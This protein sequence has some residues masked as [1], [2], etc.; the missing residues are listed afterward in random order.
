MIEDKASGQSII[1]DLKNQGYV[2]IKPIKPRLDKITRFASIVE[3]FQ[4]GDVLLPK[5]SSFNRILLNELTSFPNSKHDDIIDSISQFLS[6]SK[7]TMQQKIVR[8][9]IL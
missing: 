4:R 6:F 1:Q 7:E 2:N 8:M 3:M 5:E 9:R